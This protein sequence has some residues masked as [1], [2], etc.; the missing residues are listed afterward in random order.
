M[1]DTRVRSQAIDLALQEEEADMKS[2]NHRQA[3]LSIN[4]AG[5]EAGNYNLTDQPLHPDLKLVRSDNHRF[6]ACFL[7]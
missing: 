1:T 3:P 4:G 2:T 7:Y 6:S 5:Q